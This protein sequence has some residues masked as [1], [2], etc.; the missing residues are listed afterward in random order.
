LYNILDA[1]EAIARYA[2][3]RTG[4]WGTGWVRKH[5][6]NTVFVRSDHGEAIN[7]AI[8]A[9]HSVPFEHNVTVTGFLTKDD[10][11]HELGHV[12]DNNIG[13]SSGAI[14]PTWFGGGPSDA[15][16][17]A[18]GG[19]PGNC[20]LRFMC[21]QN[22]AINVAVNYAWPDGS[23]GNHSVADDFAETFRYAV[24]D[25]DNKIAPVPRIWWMNAY[26]TLRG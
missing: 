18:L 2:Q 14:R 23:Y 25:P 12:L 21:S 9:K 15:M 20:F 6:G 22:Y 5:L 19:N 11:V 26:I 4:N 10:V 1:G 16:V 24:L 3:N 17:S 13:K 8:G 7:H